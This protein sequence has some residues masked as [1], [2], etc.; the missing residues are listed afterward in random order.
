MTSAGV[1]ADPPKETI[2]LRCPRLVAS[3]VDCN[4]AQAVL[5]RLAR[6]RFAPLMADRMARQLGAAASW[7]ALRR[8]ASPLRECESDHEHPGILKLPILVCQP[9]LDCVA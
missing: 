2:Q 9:L 8:I 3:D 4:D 7:A 5:E 1:S 6:F